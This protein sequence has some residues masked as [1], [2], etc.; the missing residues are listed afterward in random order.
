V[1]ALI[2]AD[3]LPALAFELAQGLESPATVLGRYNLKVNDPAVDALLDSPG[4]QKL[5]TEAV[6]EARKADGSLDRLRSLARQKLIEG[7]EKLTSSFGDARHTLAER[8]QL[9]RALA[10]VAGAED[11]PAPP[12]PI[13][14]GEKFVVNIS[15]PGGGVVSASVSTGQGTGPVVDGLVE[16]DDDEAQ[17]HVARVARDHSPARAGQLADGPAGGGADDGRRD[18]VGA[19][20][21]QLVRPVAGPGG[22]A[23]DAVP[24]E[25]VPADVAPVPRAGRRRGAVITDLNQL[26]A[27]GEV[28]A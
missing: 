15:I 5:F 16:P 27:F 24:A 13:G 9:F 1:P 11:P 22:P 25:V 8:V 26:D 3:R 6:E 14:A 17:E 7:M 2:P 18:R 23:D 10:K 20:E 12:P 21:P 4:F 19:G 28:I